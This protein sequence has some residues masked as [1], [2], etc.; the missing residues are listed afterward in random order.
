MIRWKTCASPTSG[1]PTQAASHDGVAFGQFVFPPA[2]SAGDS[3]R[4]TIRYSCAFSALF[5]VFV[6]ADAGDNNLMGSIL[7]TKWQ[8]E[9]RAD[10]SARLSLGS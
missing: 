7:V 10:N 4:L 5:L 3:I 6:F 9:N 8:N 1:P 2:E